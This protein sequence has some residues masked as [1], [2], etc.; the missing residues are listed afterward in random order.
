MYFISHEESLLSGY[1]KVNHPEHYQSSSLETIDVIEAFELN[2]S[3]GSAIKYILRAGKK[4]GE[5]S[6][7]DL[8][9]A[10]WSLQ[11]EVTRR[12]K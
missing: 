11:R 3:M 12:Q 2:F 4:P 1:E 7:E 10:I 6:T 5:E 8:K 9:K